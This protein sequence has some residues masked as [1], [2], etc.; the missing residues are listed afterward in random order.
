MQI[1]IDVFVQTRVRATDLRTEAVATVNISV[2][3]VND[4][5]PQ[6]HV[7]TVQNTE[8]VFE[9][10]KKNCEKFEH[11]QLSDDFIFVFGLWKLSNARAEC[12]SKL[13]IRNNKID[14]YVNFYFI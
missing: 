2:I 3:N 14:R 5:D 11:M 13:K 6:V 9:Q 7:L 8:I 4:W 10:L 12:V 1:Y